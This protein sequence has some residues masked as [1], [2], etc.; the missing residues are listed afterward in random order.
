L[1]VAIAGARAPITALRF[2]EFSGR[3]STRRCRVRCQPHTQATGSPDS[4]GPREH[5]GNLRA[6]T[7]AGAG[8]GQPPGAELVPVA[9]DHA[10]AAVRAIRAAAVAVVHVTCIDVVQA[11]RD[12]DA[13]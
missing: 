5:S 11:V 8:V 7:L 1:I 12:C 13:P 3:D 9:L 4:R 6:A 2:A 10:H